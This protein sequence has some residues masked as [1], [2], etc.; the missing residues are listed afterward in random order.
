MKATD[1]SDRIANEL[2]EITRELSKYRL[3]TAQEK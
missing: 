2:L 3:L 1:S